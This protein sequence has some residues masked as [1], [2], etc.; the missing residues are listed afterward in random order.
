MV[1]EEV[2][3]RWSVCLLWEVERVMAATRSAVAAEEREVGRAAT[4]AA[5][6]ATVREVARRA[7]VRA[8][9]WVV[10]RSRIKPPQRRRRG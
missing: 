6:M 10:V 1:A 4:P 9:A 7:A 8:A 3:G 5:V 2:G